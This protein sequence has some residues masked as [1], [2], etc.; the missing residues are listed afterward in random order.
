VHAKHE[1][2][3]FFHGRIAPVHEAGDLSVKQ[4]ANAIAAAEKFVHVRCDQHDG[5]SSPAFFFK[6]FVNKP[7]R[8]GIEAVC[9]AVTDYQIRSAGKTAR[10]Y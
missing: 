6:E 2:A 1:F 5:G 3:D 10:Q 4:Y 9:R 7:N 8:F